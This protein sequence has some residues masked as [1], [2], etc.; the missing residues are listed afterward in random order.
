M[1][2]PSNPVYLTLAESQRRTSIGNTKMNRCHVFWT[3]SSHTSRLHAPQ[4]SVLLL[5]YFPI[6]LQ[7]FILYLPLYTSVYILQLH[8]IIINMEPMASQ[9]SNYYS[10]Q[11]QEAHLERVLAHAL[12]KTANLHCQSNV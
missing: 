7:I 6:I 8:F 3:L 9:V 2:N 1:K 5:P 11:N 4:P 10:Q 12:K